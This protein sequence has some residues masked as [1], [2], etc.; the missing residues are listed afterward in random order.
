M[1]SS[2]PKAAVLNA[3]EVVDTHPGG[4]EKKC[5]KCKEYLDSLNRFVKSEHRKN[6]ASEVIQP[7][8]TA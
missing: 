7:A 5:F 2:N 6:R 1:A 4:L 8:H 3:K